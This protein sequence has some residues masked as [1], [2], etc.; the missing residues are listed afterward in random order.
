MP[1][2]SYAKGP[3]VP[4]AELTL[5]DALSQT[6]A[7]FPDR[8]A[9]VACHQKQRFTWHEFGRTVTHVA[10][11]I[12]GLRPSALENQAHG[13]FRVSGTASI[14]SSRQRRMHRSFAERLT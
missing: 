13:V 2:L 1:D 6:A 9:L 14:Y 8:D 5:A 10:W 7:R 12:A 11:G 3:S 4:L